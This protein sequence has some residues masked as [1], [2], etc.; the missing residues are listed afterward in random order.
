MQNNAKAT[1]DN[2]ERK[3]RSLMRWYPRD[4]RA[5][6]E[7]GFIGA[8]L[9]EVD[10]TIRFSGVPRLY[11]SIITGGLHQR[12]FPYEPVPRLNLVLL[13][14]ATFGCTLYISLVTFDPSH[15]VEGGI[16][17]FSNAMALIGILMVGALSCALIQAGRAFR[18]LA[19]LAAVASVVL[20]VLASLNHWMGPSP[21]LAIG[22]AFF[23]LFAGLY[24]KK[25][26]EKYKY[27]V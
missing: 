27:Y 24:S 6:N 3:Y 23:N 1:K 13:Y 14:L 18:L 10:D 12:L 15:R 19:V 25:D 9:D 7:D 4:W 17:P 5:Q 8:L 20:G 26:L 22:V 21:G 11:F 16:W 2:L